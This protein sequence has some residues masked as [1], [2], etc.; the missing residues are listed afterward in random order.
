MNL[1]ELKEAIAK[2]PNSVKLHPN[3]LFR[4]HADVNW[5]LEPSFSRIANKNELNRIKALQMEREIVNKFSTSASK[6]LPIEMTIDL[7]LARF[8]SP[9][10]HGIDFMGWF[11]VMQHF[12]APT[13]MLD[14]TT[15][16]WV[17]LYF[18][19]CEQ[20][21]CDGAIWIVDF[22]KATKHAEKK[23]NGSDFVSLMMHPESQDIVVLITAFNS[24]ER[25][26][27]QQGRFS[28][29]TNPLINHESQLN[30]YDSLIKIDIPKELKPDILR[31]LNQMNITAKTLFPGIDGLGKSIYEY[32]NL[33]DEDSVIK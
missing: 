31:E 8:K 13:R 15:S 32:C 2:Y 18:A 16:P 27:A 21:D 33:W 9:D 24:N 22:R 20:K 3:F 14:W 11:S 19:C 12:S 4:G 30:E 6:L 10:G 5:K 17:A 25:I 26:E 28:I 23:L 7:T 1:T 29:S